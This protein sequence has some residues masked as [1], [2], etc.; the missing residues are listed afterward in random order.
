MEARFMWRSINFHLQGESGDIHGDEW[1]IRPRFVVPVDVCSSC[2]INEWIYLAWWTAIQIYQSCRANVNQ[3]IATLSCSSHQQ[4]VLPY[5]VGSFRIMMLNG[6]QVKA[7]KLLILFLGWGLLQAHGIASTSFH[8]PVCEDSVLLGHSARYLP[9][10]FFVSCYDY[11]ADD[12]SCTLHMFFD[13][14][15][16]R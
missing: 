14:T 16:S 10:S 11:Y 3:I 4:N 12:I 8:V 2:R 5:V 7:I 15:R 9:V 6:T 13:S 1:A